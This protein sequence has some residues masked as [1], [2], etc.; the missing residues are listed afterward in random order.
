M[1]SGG[2]RG[3]WDLG[4]QKGNQK[5]GYH[6]KCKQIKSLIEKQNKTYKQ[7]NKNQREH[8]E[9]ERQAVWLYK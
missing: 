7:T 4:L 9:T 2:G 3:R 8:P 6:L 5:G 1:Q